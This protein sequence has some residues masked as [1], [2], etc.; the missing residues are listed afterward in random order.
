MPK[1][2]LITLLILLITCFNNA[3]AA[4]RMARIIGGRP[5]DSNAW[6]WMA[7]LVYKNSTFTND[8]FCGGSLI[9]KDWVL[10]AAHCVIDANNSDFEVIINHAQLDS[11]SGERLSVE[12]ILYHPLYNDI[13]L[14]NDL[15]LIKLAT[16]SG[17]TPIN[18]L[19]PFSS[20][21]NANTVATALGWGATSNMP[22]SLPLDLQQVDLPIVDHSRCDKAMGD[23]TDNMLC[24]GDGLGEK[25]TCFGDSGGPLVVFDTE[26][27][28]WRQ[29]GITSWGF[30]CASPGFFGV[31]T[32][33]SKSLTNLNYISLFFGYHFH[34]K[35]HAVSFA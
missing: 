35:T 14:E 11:H 29:V 21:D 8:V 6:P 9:A 31:Y 25:D 2:T 26:S 33:L 30:D 5:A 15:A 24:A 12:S 18:V 17:N 19:A 20:Q 3:T 7:G 16:P 4:E 22:L 1:K 28:S 34:K 27:N 13:N 23:I 10:T 32:R